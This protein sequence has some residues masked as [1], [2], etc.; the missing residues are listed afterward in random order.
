M[1][2]NFKFTTGVLQGGGTLSSDRIPAEVRMHASIATTVQLFGVTSFLYDKAL[3]GLDQGALFARPAEVSN[4]I[5][6]IAGHLAYSRTGVARTLGARLDPP[7]PEIFAR[8]VKDAAPAAYPDIAEIRSAWTTAP[9]SAAPC[10][11]CSRPFPNACC[12]PSAGRWLAR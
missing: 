11:K 7:W 10:R 2:V 4:P 1:K 12:G 6:W 3:D 9:I 8:G 5:V